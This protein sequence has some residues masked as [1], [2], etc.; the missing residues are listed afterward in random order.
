MLAI[1]LSTYRYHSWTD[2]N[3]EY[4]WN[5]QYVS[6]L[7]LVNV[8]EETDNL[9]IHGTVDHSD[10]YDR[11]EN[12]YWWNQYNIRRSIFMGD[13]VYAISSAG[14]TATNLTS[15][16]ESAS[17]EL[18]YVNPYNTYY[19]DDV[20]VEEDERGEESTSDDGGEGSGGSSSGSSGSEPVRD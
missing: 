13:F 6:K 3:G 15:M 4:H 8:S 9:S 5:Y 1:P 17:V 18:A 16:S 7:I 10:L 2:S 20:V 11:G 19:Y 12:Q 14:I